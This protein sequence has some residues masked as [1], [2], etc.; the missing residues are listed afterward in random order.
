MANYNSC[1]R[2]NYFRVTDEEKYK[3]LFEGLTAED[4][5]EDFTETRDGVIWHGFGSYSC[6]FW[7]SGEED[8]ECTR[9]DFYTQLQEILPE[10]EAFI[11]LENG[12]EKLRY[13]T[14]F[15]EIVTKHDIRYVSVDDM[16]LAEARNML[17]NPDFTTQLDY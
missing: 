3:K 15:A 14:G 9:D 17:G 10:D 6:I 8:E 13:L 1:A 7:T 4:R 16:A 11:Y 2:T 5:V 12:Y